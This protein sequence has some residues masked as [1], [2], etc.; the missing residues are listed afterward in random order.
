MTRSTHQLECPYCGGTA[1]R[2]VEAPD[3]PDRFSDGRFTGDPPE[4]A[5]RPTDLRTM[6][7]VRDVG[8]FDPSTT[9][10]WDEPQ[11]G[12]WV[13]DDFLSWVGF[14]RRFGILTARDREWACVLYRVERCASCLHHFDAYY[15]FHPSLTLDDLFPHLFA[16]E[17]RSLEI[18]PDEPLPALFVHR[19][20]GGARDGDAASARE[21]DRATARALGVWW[22][23]AVVAMLLVRLV[24]ERFTLLEYAGAAASLLLGLAASG[25][26]LHALQRLL[27]HLVDT[28]PMDEVI[29]CGERGV[30]CRGRENRVRHWVA[31]TRYRYTGR[32]ATGRTVRT[33]TE[34]IGG[35]V[36]VL[37]FLLVI[38]AVEDRS[39]PVMLPRLVDAFWWFP[40][41]Y[42]VGSSLQLGATTIHYVLAGLTRIPLRLEQFSPTDDLPVL[43]AVQ[44]YVRVTGTVVAVLL[45][46]L[47]ATNAVLRTL[48]GAD[49]PVAWVDTWF[50]VVVLLG[51]LLLG[52]THERSYVVLA[53]VVT[54]VTVALAAVPDA[55][56]PAPDWFVIQPTT[57]WLGLVF[58]AMLVAETRTTNHLVERAM[59]NT[60]E[61]RA[62]RL[63]RDAGTLGTE[64][65]LRASAALE[66][67]RVVTKMRSGAVAAAAWIPLVASVVLP[68]TLEA[69]LGQLV[70]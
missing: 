37:S 1:S 16:P 66:A 52:V 67:E 57:V 12:S 42:M 56:I 51:L 38:L 63:L 33:T 3:L 55:D 54:S 48:S 4:L 5:D 43:R 65:V 25:V 41:A 59:R 64:Q 20:T 18:V 35:V 61:A 30:G 32:P 11:R 45:I 22:G 28:S 9:D 26:L 23:M 53:L 69:L 6:P 24:V 47:L 19:L 7:Y 62:A 36:A 13:G 60:V 50:L 17:G 39:T 44:R 8:T 46:T 21:R 68:V 29:A 14:D 40:V 2:V 34:L 49:S 70:P 58:T 27:E 15:S 31:F 10:D